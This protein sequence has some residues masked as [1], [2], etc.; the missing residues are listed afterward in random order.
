MERFWNIIHYF[1][2]KAFYKFHLFFNKINPL[3]FV[4]K[5]P[6]GNRH[7]KKLNIENP[8]EELNKTFKRPDI[9]ISSIWAGGFMY[10][11][12]ILLLWGLLNLLSAVFLIKLNLQFYHFIGF[13]CLSLII[14]HILLF[15]NNKY[16]GYFK[17]FDKMNNKEKIKWAWIS[18]MVV[19]SILF[20]IIGSFVVLSHQ[21]HSSR[22]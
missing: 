15:K 20:I 8:V 10:G 7:F 19:L 9:G 5:S 11:L 17:K 22:L 13:F 1:V 14:N 21:Y 2:Y 6:I 4:Y 16:L 3:L 18:F 12:V